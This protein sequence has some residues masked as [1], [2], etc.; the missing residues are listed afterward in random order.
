MEL[1]DLELELVRR[2]TV[3]VAQIV[4]CLKMVK[5]IK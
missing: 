4:T 5:I 2:I 1:L 3:L